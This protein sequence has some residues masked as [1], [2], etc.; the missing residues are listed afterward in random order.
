MGIQDLLSW[1]KKAQYV[2]E[3]VVKLTPGSETD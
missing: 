1:A 2:D 3:D